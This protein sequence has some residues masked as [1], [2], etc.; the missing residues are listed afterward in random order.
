MERRHSGGSKVIASTWGA[1]EEDD[2]DNDGKGDDNGVDGGSD[3]RWQ[4]G[5]VT[6][7]Y[8]QSRA[9]WRQWAEEEGMTTRGKEDAGDVKRLRAATTTAGGSGDR[10]MALKER[11]WLEREAVMM[12]QWQGGVAMVR[13]AVLVDA[14]SEEGRDTD[15]PKRNQCSTDSYH[16]T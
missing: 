1:A 16:T 2:N 14:D 13:L 7:G 4:G 6:A 15:W 3:Y 11:K 12:M 10:A 8:A 5:P 9:R